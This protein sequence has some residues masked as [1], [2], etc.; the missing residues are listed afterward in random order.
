MKVLFRT[1]ASLQ[2][3][4]GHVTRCLTLAHALGQRGANCRFACRAL[5]GNMLEQIRHH[6]F[7]VLVLPSDSSAS[8]EMVADKKTL[9]HAH[10]LGVCW[11]VDAEQTIE[12]LVNSRPD[13][14]V[15]DHYALDAHWESMLRPHCDRIMAVDDLADRDHD[16]DLLLDQNLIAEM[17]HRY[18]NRVSPDCVRLLGPGYALLQSEYAELHPRTPPRTGSVHR[19]LVYFGGADKHNLTGQTIRAF[20]TLDRPDIILDVVINPGSPNAADVRE[21]TKNR[22]NIILHETLPSLA[23]LM[24]KADLAIGAGGATSWERCCL[25]LPSLIITIAENQ[26][27]IAAELDRKRLVHWLGHHDTVNEF[28][29][30]N[31]L[32]DA[33][34]AQRMAD[35]SNRCRN[36]VDAKGTERVASIVSLNP[37]TPLKA[38]PAYVDDEELLLKWVNDPLVRDSSFSSDV[39]APEEH[40][41]WLYKRLRDPD[42]CRVYIVETAEGLPIGQVRF[43][44]TNDIWEIGF[45]LDP[46]VRDKALGKKLLQAAIKGFRQSISGVLVFG[47]VKKDN[48]VSRKVFEDFTFT[49]EREK[50]EEGKA[51]AIC[52]DSDSW[53]N[54]YI[55]GLLLGWLATGHQCVWV[56]SSTDLPGGDLCFYLSYGRIVDQCFRR[57]YKH[58]LVVHESELPKGKGWSPVTWQILEGCNRI[59]VV[60]IEADEHVDSGVVYAQRW[61]EFEGDELVDEIRNAQ[62]EAT[63][64]LCRWFVGGYPKSA[65]QFQYQ[66]GE[67]SFYPHRGEAD[68][69]LNLAEPLSDQFNLLRVVDNQR[70]PAFFTLSGN[71]YFVRVSRSE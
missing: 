1:D 29:L 46:A 12:A 51:I 22:S 37:S 59:P 19:I 53:M 33:L 65:E 27:P 20:C 26:K 5:E 45:A 24:L 55:P 7:E 40:R 43:E 61:I 38:R 41:A 54:E 57:K 13:W 68:S 11:E 23:P 66:Q 6:G 8:I 9:D 32:K 2:I 64:E 17:D 58:N 47:R 36:M 14:L 4:S 69:E 3:G 71:K 44:L 42:K 60:L 21:L 34:D 10:W 15:V 63:F 52:S 16:C 31:A 50:V 28:S 70:Y 56:H 49:P 18:D 39:I 67:E 30:T 48:A 62:A 35:W 25:G